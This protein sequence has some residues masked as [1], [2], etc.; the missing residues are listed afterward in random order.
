[1]AFDACNFGIDGVDACCERTDGLPDHLCECGGLLAVVDDDGL[2]RNSAVALC[3]FSLHLAHLGRTLAGENGFGGCLD[4]FFD[5]AGLV[6]GGI[7]QIGKSAFGGAAQTV[8]IVL[9]GDGLVLDCSFE[10]SAAVADLLCECHVALL[11]GV[12]DLLTGHTHLIAYIADLRGYLLDSGL[13]LTDGA[14]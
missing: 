2:F 1:M 12:D 5:G 10:I 7:A 9:Q 11:D 3:Q 4:G 6:A 14:V 8:E 13:Y